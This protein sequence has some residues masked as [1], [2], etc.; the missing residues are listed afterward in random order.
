[1]IRVFA[2]R[3]YLLQPPDYT[4]RNKQVLLLYWVE[5]QADLSLCWSHWSYCRFCRALARFIAHT[6]VYFHL[7]SGGIMREV[8]MFEGYMYV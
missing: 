2:D 1:M 7:F 6:N 4:K 5:L 8:G 3:T